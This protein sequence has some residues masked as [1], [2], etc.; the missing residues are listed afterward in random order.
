MTGI[1]TKNNERRLLFILDL[2][3]TLLHR[4][5]KTLQRSLTVNHP[6]SRSSDCC[7]KGNPIYYR[8]GYRSFLEQLFT[9]G[10]V[11]VWT[12]AMPKNAYPMVL[13]VFSGFLTRD[14]V[15]NYHLYGCPPLAVYGENKLLF[16]WTQSECEV[17]RIP[18]VEKPDFRKRLDLVWE[19][20]PAYNACNTVMIDDTP[21]KLDSHRDNLIAIPEFLVTEQE[22]DHTKDQVLDH[23]T[24]YL[25]SI[26]QSVK[27]D[28]ISVTKL[29]TSR[30][31]L[32]K[33]KERLYAINDS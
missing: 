9:W 30:P 11:A 16:L 7:V 1:I 18:G 4:I 3:R 21:L 26:Y 10:E 19:K 8:P 23:L 22:V 14:S 29:L 25:K 13:N 6:Q 24:D 28:D 2:N 12:S 32:I 33:E 27:E 15:E 31:F 17:R 20:F 5:T